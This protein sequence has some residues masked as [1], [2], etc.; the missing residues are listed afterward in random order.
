MH[1][2]DFTTDRLNE[3]CTVTNILRD[4]EPTREV[5]DSD[6]ADGS[7]VGVLSQRVDMTRDRR[8]FLARHLNKM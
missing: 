8:P 2:R 3:T 5:I 6:K 7:K 1:L 4:S